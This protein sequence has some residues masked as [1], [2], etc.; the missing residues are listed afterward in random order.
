MNKIINNYVNRLS[1]NERSQR[2]IKNVVG[3]IGVK[4]LSVLTNFLLVPICIDMVSIPK[5][6][7]WMTLSSIV[8]WVSFFDIGVSNGLRNKFTEAVTHNDFLRAK[9][10]VSTAYFLLGSIFGFLWLVIILITGFIDFGEVLNFQS[11]LDIN[12][13][14]L[15]IIL[16]TYFCA[17]FVLK[18]ISTITTADQ[19]P[20][21]SSVIDTIGQVAILIILL[22]FQ[23]SNIFNDSLVAL[24]IV[25]TAIPLLVVLFANIL[26]FKKRYSKV[27][28]SLEYFDKV[29]I[30]DIFGL[31]FKF[32][33]IQIAGLIQFQTA[34]FLIA[35]FFAIENVTF[36][37]IA[38]KYF[39]ILNMTFNILLAPQWSAMTNAFIKE[40]YRWI[41]RSVNVF[42]YVASGFLFLGLLM[43]IFSDFVYD[44]WLNNPEI[45]ITR[46]LSL[47]AF[48]FFSTANFSGIF[49]S[50]LN[51]F[52]AIKIQYYLCWITPFIFVITFYLLVYY[53]NIGIVSILI[54]MLFSNFNGLIVAPIQYFQIM[55]GKRGIWLS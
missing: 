7:I 25:S 6:G 19:K 53:T 5:Y 16:V 54:A 30:R 47:F 42:L 37:N 15:V 22:I 11:E 38:F 10:L 49:I 12:F 9:R 24:A 55:K 4:G 31:G 35:K 34:N 50:V 13:N 33:I 8:A 27:A 43:F 17:Q 3:L 18:L 28:P 14:R 46:E 39:S 21:I 36:Y 45:V 2:Y 48:I 20:F 1:K 40:D 32:F 26:L 51:G 41:R 52:G 23:R 29:L 44:I